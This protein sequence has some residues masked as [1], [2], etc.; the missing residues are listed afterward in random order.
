V[1]IG[2]IAAGWLADLTL[3]LIFGAIIGAIVAGEGATPE[4][5]SRRMNASVELMLSS[6]FVG[7][8]FTGVGG[9]VA[10]AIAKQQHL[11][12]AAAVG[13]LSLGLGLSFSLGAPSTQPLWVTTVGLLLTVPFAV[14]GGYYRLK[15]ER[16]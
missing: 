10:A 8:S 5:V 3:S 9:Y 14:F 4:E 11:R 6:L 16:T 1:R 7:L 2:A 13:L 15:T 12:H